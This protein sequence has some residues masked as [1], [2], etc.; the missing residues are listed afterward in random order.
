[1]KTLIF[2]VTA[3][4]HHPL[5][6]MMVSQA[7]SKLHQMYVITSQTITSYQVQIKWKLRSMQT[8]PFPVVFMQLTNLNGLIQ[9]EFTPKRQSPSLTMKY[10]LLVMATMLISKKSTGL[11]ETHGVPIGVK[12][13]S[14]V[15]R[16]TVKT[17]VL[18]LIVLLVFPHTP[19]LT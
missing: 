10:Q 7:V 11:V 8:V 18:N 5:L 14:S 4:G 6:V 2:A 3:Y 16:C 9:V 12:W 1:M 17:W 15:W 13:V 19:I